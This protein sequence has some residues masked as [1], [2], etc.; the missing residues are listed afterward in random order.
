MLGVIY[1]V[2]LWGDTNA[3]TPSGS[4]CRSG[5]C[6]G[7]VQVHVATWPLPAAREGWRLQE[8]GR[9]IPFISLRLT[10]PLSPST[11]SFSPRFTC[12]NFRYY[13]ET[14]LA[15]AL[16]RK[17]ENDLLDYRASHGATLAGMT[18]YGCSPVAPYSH[19]RCNGANQCVCNRPPLPL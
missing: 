17:L 3:A 8:M 19:A 2:L 9:M 6:A 14:L 1:G 10:R 18:R 15:E 5:F 13:G 11:P 12:S 4:R 7:I 16:P